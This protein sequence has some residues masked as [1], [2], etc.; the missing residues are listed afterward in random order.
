MLRTYDYEC[1][2]EFIANENQPIA[3]EAEGR[4]G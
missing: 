1:N 4:V 2:S 3:D